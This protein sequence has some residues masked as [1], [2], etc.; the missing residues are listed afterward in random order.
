MAGPCMAGHVI[1]SMLLTSCGVAF[2][3]RRNMLVDWFIYHESN[4][5]AGEYFGDTVLV[6]GPPLLSHSPEET[7]KKKI[8]Y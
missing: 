7:M 3:L 6:C 2:M 4:K 1:V 5:E 8:E